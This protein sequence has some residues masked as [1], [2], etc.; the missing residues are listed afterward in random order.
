MPKE[1]PAGQAKADEM[2]SLTRMLGLLDLFSPGAPIWTAEEIIRH[3]G[4]SRSTCYRYIRA[5]HMAGLISP[6]ENG[7]FVLGSRILELDHQIRER[8]PLYNAAGDPMIQL[9]QATGHSTVVCALYSDSVM[10]IRRHLVQAAPETIYSRGYRRPLFRGASSKII[11]AH[12][13]AHQLK[14]LYAPNRHEIATAGLGADWPDFRAN[15]LQ[16][17][18]S[19]HCVTAGEASAGATGIAA[20]IFNR[21]GAALGS[22]AVVFRTRYYRH[23]DHDRLAEAV[24]AAAREATAAVHHYHHQ[25]DLAARSVNPGRNSTGRV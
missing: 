12:L 5:L 25:R 24:I 17:R 14:R 2:G 22:I 3:T 4:L 1:R 9:S 18:K 7:H 23:Q 20:P 21:R 8:D 10:C 15:L 19:G 6:V 13:P 16:M 11:L